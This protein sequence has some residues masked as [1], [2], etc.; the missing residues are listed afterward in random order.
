MRGE[1]ACEV[2]AI[3]YLR[4]HPDKLDSME[5]LVRTTQLGLGDLSSH[6]I[7]SGWFY[8]NE[9]RSSKF[10][11]EQFLPIADVGQQTISPSL[12]QACR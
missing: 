2:A 1:N 8:Q 11:L 7:P 6:L 3:D 4:H 10:I 5:N 9:L 12:V